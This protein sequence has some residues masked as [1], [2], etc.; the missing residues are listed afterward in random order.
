MTYWNQ[1]AGDSS[2]HWW[3]FKVHDVT[4]PDDWSDLIEENFRRASTN[5]CPIN[6]AG[7]FRTGRHYEIDLDEFQA[8]MEVNSTGVF[9]GMR[10]VAPAMR[11]AGSGSIVNISSVAGLGATPGAFAYGASK[12]AV[13][14][15]TKTAAG[16]LVAEEYA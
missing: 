9:L 11:E 12:W 3:V 1:R 16:S 8:V 10:A 5:R 2:R 7:I 15:M 6:N 14:G 4:D 13:R